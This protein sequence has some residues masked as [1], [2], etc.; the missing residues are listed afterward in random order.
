VADVPPGVWTVT[1]T[2]PTACAG[3]RT[4]IW[5][6]DP[7]VTLIPGVVPKKTLASVAKFLPPA[8]TEVPPAVVPEVGLRPVTVRAL[9]YVNW[10]DEEVAEVPPGVTTCTS[11]VA[12]A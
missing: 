1:S 5:V 2:V 8:V 12:A 3:D 7:T 6:Y 11:T 4:V 10:S 9:R